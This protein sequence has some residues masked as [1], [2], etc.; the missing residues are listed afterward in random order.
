MLKSFF[1]SAGQ[2]ITCLGTP[3]VLFFLSPVWLTLLLSC[4][5]FAIG[6]ASPDRIFA[7]LLNLSSSGWLSTLMSFWPLVLLIQAVRFIF[8]LLVVVHFILI[9]S[10]SWQK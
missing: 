5:C 1:R 9:W 8:L 2:L 10:R 7:S 4:A 3:F 6:F